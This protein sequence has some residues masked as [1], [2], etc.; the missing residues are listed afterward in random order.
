MQRERTG[1][2]GGGEKTPRHDGL[3]IV[4]PVPRENLAVSRGNGDSMETAGIEPAQDSPRDEI[5]AMRFAES[6]RRLRD[7]DRLAQRARV[8]RVG[9]GAAYLPVFV[10]G[11]GFCAV[12]RLYHRFGWL[13]YVGIADDYEKRLRQHACEKPWWDEVYAAHVHFVSTR[14]EA[15]RVEAVLIEQEDPPLNLAGPGV[16]TY[17]EA[18]AWLGDQAVNEER[19]A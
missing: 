17:I 6:T 7:R 10:T 5:T 12:Y 11:Q 13:M 4:P 16:K 9:V 14:E 3:Q 15:Y 18:L 19:N 1:A 8:R 2:E